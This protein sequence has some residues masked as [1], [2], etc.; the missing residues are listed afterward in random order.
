[1]ILDAFEKLISNIVE[2]IIKSKSEWGWFFVGVIA[3]VF[4][5]VSIIMIAHRKLILAGLFL[6]LG[7]VPIFM[8][9]RS[10]KKR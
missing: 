4:F 6:I 1:M 3:L 9:I 7:L 2:D 5:A 10:Q 8:R